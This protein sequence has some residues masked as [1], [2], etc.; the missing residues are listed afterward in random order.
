MTNQSLAAVNKN[1]IDTVRGALERMKPQMA[2]A[3]PKHLTPDRLLRVAITAIQNTPKLLECERTSLYSAIM[4]C[5]QLGLEPDGVLG[6]AY[7]IPFGNKVQFVAGYKGLISLARNSGDVVS[8]SAH[9]VYENDHF[10]YAFGLNEKLEHIP[11]RKNRGEII[12]FYAIARFKDGGYHW[13][14]MSKEEVDAIKENS[15]G[16]KAAVSWSK[17]PKNK[18]N[19]GKIDSPWVGSFSEMGKKTA[20]RRISKYLPMSV[21]RAMAMSDSLDRGR[22]VSMDNHGILTEQKPEQIENNMQTIDAETGEVFEAEKQQA[23]KTDLL[24]K[25]DGE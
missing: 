1:P 5:A 2:L 16:Y 12:F 17:N 24:S 23:E 18:Y 14:V 25:F 13:D 22:H 6:Q 21:Q 15:S 11:A 20:I 10:D 19:A 9:E 7:L 3:L 4:T 8:M